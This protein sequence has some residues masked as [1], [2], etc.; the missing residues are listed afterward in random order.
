MQQKNVLV[1][2]SKISEGQL[3]LPGAVVAWNMG[4]EVGGP[5]AAFNMFA[6]G[7]HQYRLF[8]P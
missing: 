4:A 8:L 2:E 6:K 1:F 7:L 5:P 3:T